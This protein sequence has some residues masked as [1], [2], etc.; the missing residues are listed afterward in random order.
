[1]TD[2]GSGINTTTAAFHVVDEYGTV[3]PSGPVSVGADG[4]YSFTVMLQASRLGSDSNG[5]RYEVVVTVSD[6]AGNAGS[7]SAIVTVPHDQGK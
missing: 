7:A 2:A 5:R 3:H 4:R 1:M 6:N